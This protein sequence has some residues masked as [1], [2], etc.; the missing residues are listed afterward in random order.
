MSEFSV[1]A[2]AAYLS[3]HEDGR[4]VSQYTLIEQQIRMYIATLPRAHGVLCADDVVATG[5]GERLDCGVDTIGSKIFKGRRL[6][7]QRPLN[8]G[9]RFSTNA[10]RASR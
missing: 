5:I 2:C 9:R 10:L 4:P 1:P 6:H 7:R 3:E 8:S